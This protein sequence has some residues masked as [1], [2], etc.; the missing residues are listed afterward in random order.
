MK[1]EAYAEQAGRWLPLNCAGWYNSPMPNR[2]TP[3]SDRHRGGSGS[4]KTTLANLVRERVAQTASPTCLTTPMKTIDLPPTS[5]RRSTSITPL[6]RLALLIHH[7]H[8]RE[9]QA[10]DLPL[11]D[12]KTHAHRATQR[13]DPQPVIMVEG[14]FIFGDAEL[15][16]LLD[17]KIFVDTHLDIRFIRRLDATSASVAAPPKWSCTNT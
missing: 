2:T 3:L 5:A 7:V 9:N 16:K 4:G 12:F 11:Y 17:V 1:D 10:I 6:P 15:R 14:I 13:I 8:C